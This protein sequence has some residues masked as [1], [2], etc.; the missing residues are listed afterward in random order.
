MRLR[1]FRH[2]VIDS[3][4][5]TLI[6]PLLHQVDPQ[7]GC[8]ADRLPAASPTLWI[9]RFNNGFKG[10]PGNAL[11]HVFKKQ[12]FACLFPINFNSARFQALL[13]HALAVSLGG[14]LPVSAE[15]IRVALDK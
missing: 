11:L 15:L 6:E 9:V 3:P 2:Q 14:I 12:L 7:H 10:T 1:I 13:F 4:R 8:Q 5:E